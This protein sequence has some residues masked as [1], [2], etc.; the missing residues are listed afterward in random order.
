[1]PT[2][3]SSEASALAATRDRTWKEHHVTVKAEMDR[4]LAANRLMACVQSARSARSSLL[5][6]F[7]FCQTFF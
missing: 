2:L 1:M 6:G 3:K 5:P 4:T 7:R